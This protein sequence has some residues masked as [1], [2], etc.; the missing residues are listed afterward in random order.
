MLEFDSS[1]WGC[2]VPIG[3]GAIGVA[4]VVLQPLQHSW[5]VIAF[6]TLPQ[7]RD[8]AIEPDAQ[9]FRCGF[10]WSAS[11]AEVQ[12][13]QNSSMTVWGSDITLLPATPAFARGAQ[14][15]S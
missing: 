4:V 1:V 3:L 11:Y 7:R 5:Q 9:R 8:D 14:R 10:K 2:E 12:T 13:V 15:K 6:I